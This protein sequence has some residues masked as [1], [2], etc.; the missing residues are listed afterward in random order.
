MTEPKG[1]DHDLLDQLY[2]PIKDECEKFALAHP[3]Q[4]NPYML[5]AVWLVRRLV[6][7]G[8]DPSE[9]SVTLTAHI[10]NQ[11]NYMERMKLN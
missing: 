8:V 7:M 11:L 10:V 1:L 4:G 6:I 5:V 9:I 3:E 2:K